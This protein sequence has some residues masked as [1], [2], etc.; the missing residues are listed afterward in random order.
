MKYPPS[1]VAL[2]RELS[3][4]PG[5]GPKSAQ[6]LAFHLFEQPRED[7]ERLSRALLEAKRDLHTCPVCFNITDAD[8]CDV[9]S[10]PTRDQDLICV[11]EEPGDVIAIERSGE[12]RGLYHVLHGVLSPM[13]GVG[14][15]KLHIRPLLPRVQ[16]GQ[17]VILA[18][19]T[20]V[21]GDATAL[22]LQRLLE[23]LGAVVSRI[24]YGLPV[25]GAL[26]YADEVTLGR[27]LAGRTRVTKPG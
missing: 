3:R 4:L 13:N 22:Y 5:I 1:L 26:E 18:T 17:E 2:I 6:R 27:A 8:R 23:P 25:G 24:A 11:V 14:P 9:C 21:E 19:G 7:I 15:D 20:T 12:Y 16:A 10:D